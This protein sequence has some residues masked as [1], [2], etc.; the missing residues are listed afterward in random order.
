[1]SKLKQ[2]CPECGSELSWFRRRES[3][4]D[5]EGARLSG[6]EDYQACSNMR[7]NYES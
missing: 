6:F 7:C 4:F 5:D 2:K 1:M 3:G